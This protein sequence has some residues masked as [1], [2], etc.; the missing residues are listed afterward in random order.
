MLIEHSKRIARP[1]LG[2]LVLYRVYSH[3]HPATIVALLP[4]SHPRKHTRGTAPTERRI[5]RSEPIRVRLRLP[6]GQLI[7]TWS[8]YLRRPSS[9]SK[10]T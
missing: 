8:H 1:T 5:F 10:L 7:D 4:R 9:R 3:W 6:W 2:Q